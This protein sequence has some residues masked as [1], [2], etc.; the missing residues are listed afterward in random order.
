[1]LANEAKISVMLIAT[2]SGETT[3]R[4]WGYVGCVTVNGRLEMV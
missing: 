1:M 4:F 2:L 3:I